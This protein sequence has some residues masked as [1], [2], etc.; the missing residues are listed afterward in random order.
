MSDARSLA[1]ERIREAGELTARMLDGDLTEQIAAAADAILE[2]YRAGGKAIFCGNGGSAADATHLAGEFLGR[3]LEERRSLPAVALAD[4]IS[5]VTAIG[6]DYGFDQVFA[7][8]LE[9]VGRRGDVLVALSTSG[10]SENVIAA[11]ARAAELGVVTVGMTGSDG[12]PLAERCDLCLRVPSDETPRI[13]EAH[14]LI[15][16]ALCEFV[17]R[18]LFAT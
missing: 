17:E 10:R 13:Q 9:G 6:N 12:G 1:E 15:G 2:A 4:G 5:T 11:V 7:R 18:E 16:H 8:Q 14:M 3:Y